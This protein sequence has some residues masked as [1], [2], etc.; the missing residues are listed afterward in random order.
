MQTIDCQQMPS[1]K[2]GPLRQA[3]AAELGD[4][5]MAAV[6]ELPAQQSQ[7]FC[8]RHLSEMSYEEIAEHLGISIDG[9]GA[10]LHRARARLRELLGCVAYDQREPR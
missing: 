2:P 7:A 1:G 5:L 8:L 9:V 4:R 3:E 10:A 6:A